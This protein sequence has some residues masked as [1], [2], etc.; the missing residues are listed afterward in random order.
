MR[1]IKLCKLAVVSAVFLSF[2]STASASLIID[3]TTESLSI[4]GTPADATA[5]AYSEFLGNDPGSPSLFNQEVL[6]YP[7]QAEPN[8]I[9]S[10]PIPMW[11]VPIYMIDGRTYLRLI[12]DAQETSQKKQIDMFLGTRGIMLS[13][14]EK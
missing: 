12:Y 3:G 11:Q 13:Y 6:K 7:G 9:T 4:P 14:C 8:V 5:Y 10:D 1:T 2:L